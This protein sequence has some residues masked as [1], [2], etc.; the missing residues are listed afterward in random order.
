MERV[1]KPKRSFLLKG[2]DSNLSTLSFFSTL[3]INADTPEFSFRLDLKRSESFPAHCFSC[4]GYWL[5]SDERYTAFPVPKDSAHLQ[6]QLGGSLGAG[7]TSTT[8]YSAQ[9]SAPLPQ[10]SHPV[11]SELVVKFAK[12]NHCRNLAREA[13]IYNYLDRIPQS[14]GTIIPRCYGFFTTTLTELPSAKQPYNLPWSSVDGEHAK[15][16]DDLCDDV[17]VDEFLDEIPSE[18][19]TK[20]RSAWNSWV[21]DLKNPLVAVLILEKGGPMYNEIDD[22]D[23]LVKKDIKQ[24]IR[25]LL[26]CGVA[27]SDFRMSNLWNIIDFNRAWVLD[28][29]VECIPDAIAAVNPG[30]RQPCFYGWNPSK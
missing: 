6:L 14:S 13:W 20:E 1:R 9:V 27:H 11:P 3:T 12:L 29:G 7:R 5:H 10:L 4:K 22:Q 30:Y 24:I 15:R 21:P 8:A 26:L 25:D 19:I 18:L 2:E 16:D 17:E 23:P 28:L